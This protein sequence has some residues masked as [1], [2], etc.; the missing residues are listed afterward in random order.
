MGLPLLRSMQ[1][2]FKSFTSTSSLNFMYFG[3]YSWFVIITFFKAK[4][5]T[6]NIPENIPEKN[7]KHTR[8]NTCGSK[9]PFRQIY[10]V[11]SVSSLSLLSY[12]KFSFVAS[13]FSRLLMRPFCLLSRFASRVQSK[14]ILHHMFECWSPEAPQKKSRSHTDA[15]HARQPLVKGERLVRYAVNAVMIM[16]PWAQYHCW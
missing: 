9:P 12:I 7:R 3:S 2:G 10:A 1:P 15:P 8:K 14:S 11:S 16:M 4:T 6:G 13:R 5:N